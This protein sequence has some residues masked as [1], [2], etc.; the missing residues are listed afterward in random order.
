[1]YFR[2][3]QFE[4]R[5]PQPH[6]I[7]PNCFGEDLAHW[8]LHRMQGMRF[9]FSAVFQEDYGW[10]FWT[11]GQYWTAI[12]LMEESGE[13]PEWLISVDYDPGLNLKAR[14]YRKADAATISRLCTCIHTAL[15]TDPHI[16]EIRWCSP[17]ET[18]CG[19]T[20]G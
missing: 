5:T 6:F 12:G 20:P 19:E 7:N 15:S 11:D 18:D 3:D 17:D 16:T 13:P 4:S 9:G 2:T 8:L 14:L 1:V 10:G